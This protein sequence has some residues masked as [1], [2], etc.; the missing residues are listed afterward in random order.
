[1]GSTSGVTVQPGAS[2]VEIGVDFTLDQLGNWENLTETDGTS[3]TL[4]QDRDHNEVNEIDTD[5]THGDANVI[6]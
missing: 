2:K 4:D 3:T 1:M 6:S 5:T